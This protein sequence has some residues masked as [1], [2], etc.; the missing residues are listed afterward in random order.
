M[1]FQ[2]F[3]AA[4]KRVECILA[5]TL[6][7]MYDPDQ[8]G[9]IY[10]GDTVIEANADGTYTLTIYNDSRTSHNLEELEA[11]LYAWVVTEFG[12]EW[13]LSIN[14]CHLL[15]RM[16]AAN[17]DAYVAAFLANAPH[18]YCDVVTI[19]G[20]CGGP[21]QCPKESAELLIAETAPYINAN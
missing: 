11:H 5:A 13:G 21:N 3:K 18:A 19:A 14:A 10:D 15:S 17:P 9:I 12:E 16:Y 6:N 4:S 1:N 2:E 7:D 20:G 8:P